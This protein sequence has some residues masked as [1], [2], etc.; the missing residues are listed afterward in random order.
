MTPYELIQIKPFPRKR[1][2]LEALLDGTGLNRF[3][4]RKGNPPAFK[5]EP[6]IFHSPCESKLVEIQTLSAPEKIKGKAT[7]LHTEWYAYEEIVHGT[8]NQEQFEN[9]L[10]FNFYLSPLN[11]HYCLFPYDVTVTEMHHHPHFCLP[12]VFMKK[13]EVRNERLVIHAKTTHGFPIII[14][15]IGSFMVSGIECVAETNNNAD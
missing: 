4:L 1:S 8:Q 3:F 7:S 10:V 9:G 14:I 12:I 2:I 6:G 11:L 15:L 13:A 5:T